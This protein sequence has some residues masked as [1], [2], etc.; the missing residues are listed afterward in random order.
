MTIQEHVEILR[1]GPRTWNAWRVENP[2]IVPDLAGISLSIGD[3]QMGPMNGGPINL[4]R[5][6]MSDAPLYFATLTGA[7]MRGSDLTNADLRGARLEGVDLTGAD[8]A[9][10]Q[11]EGASLAGAVL[12]A[13]N[14]CGACLADVRGLTTDQI[15]EAEGDLGTV[16]PYDLERPPVWTAGQG[17]LHIQTADDVAEE[18][19]RGAAVETIAEPIPPTQ[20]AFRAEPE[21]EQAPEPEPEQAAAPEPYYAPEP[22]Q[23][24]AVPKEP[25]PAVPDNEPNV[26]RYTARPVAPVEQ[27]PV[28]EPEPAPAYQPFKP[29]PSM[30]PLSVHS[31]GHDAGESAEGQDENKHVS[32]LVGGPR[33]VGRRELSGPQS[34]WRDRS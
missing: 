2:S 16:L 5:T 25:T 33:R 28:Y 34:R 10:A 11:L 14:L 7:D 24:T 32:W 29:E 22:M 15:D 20:M 30:Q 19:S 4:S 18:M 17:V 21:P 1:R 26:E 6:Q 27:R 9:G 8:L 12:K 31:N 13:T 3:R 23:T